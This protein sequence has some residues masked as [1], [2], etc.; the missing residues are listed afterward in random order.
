MSTADLKATLDK[1][2]D[3]AT[4]TI[5]RE[6]FRNACDEDDKVVYLTIARRMAHARKYYVTIHEDEFIFAPR[7]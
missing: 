5:S 6:E 4:W 1:L 7:S 3:G 2:E